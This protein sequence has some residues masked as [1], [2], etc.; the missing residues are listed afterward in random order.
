[1][2]EILTYKKILKFW[3][4][5]SATW[6]MMSFEGP[7]LTAIIAR[8]KEQEFNLAAYGVAFTI[9]LII[10]SPVIMLLSAS[11]ALIENKQTFFKLRS[12]VYS[13]IVLVTVAMLVLIIPP[14]FNF[15]AIDLI[16]LPKQVAKLTHISCILLIPWA[17]AI[18]Y[19]RF[20]QGILIRNNLT[21]YVAYGTVIRVAGMIIVALVLYFLFPDIHGVYVGSAALS[22]GVIVEAIAARIM[23]NPILP[24]VLNSI[25]NLDKHLSHK[26]VFY[27][28]YPL[29]LTSFISLGFQPVVIFFI[30]KS[31][32]SL[33]SLAVLPVLNSLVFLWRSMGLS[34]PEVVIA[35]LKS[36]DDYE[37]LKKFSIRLG[38]IVFIT[39]G[40]VTLTPLADWW[41]TH[42][43]GL[44]E[45]LTSFSHV[46]LVLY[47][48]F[49]SLTVWINFQ[50][51][52]LINGRNT[53]PLTMGII[54][55]V[56]GMFAILL[57]TVNWVGMIGVVAAVLAMTFS[58][59]VSNF[60]LISPYNKALEQIKKA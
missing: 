53:K 34:I 60:Y 22:S 24:K 28:Y 44:S 6:L 32:H 26:E 11:T 16:Q 55:E 42:V 49:P 17:P 15:F 7:F 48:V 23:V 52:V 45:K 39:L 29:A 4:P 57:L 3:L 14:V 21:K 1:M 27:F 54:I 20:F 13:I 36:N 40:F 10:E 38:W 58:R 19:R 18:G 2:S 35:L 25:N 12:F 47:T 8:M 59:L 50:R 37:R 56:L 9:A 31:N 46:P 33:E 5:L 41:L 30:A 43:S 51:A